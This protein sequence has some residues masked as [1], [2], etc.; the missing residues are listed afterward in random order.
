MLLDQLQ[1]LFLSLSSTRSIKLLITSRPH[2]PVESVFQDV[3]IIPLAAH[4]LQNDI[5]AF[6]QTEVDKLEFADTLGDEVQKF[7]I[8]RA[9]GMFLWVS[10]IVDDLKKSTNTTPRAI[11][12]KLESLP[13][14]L[15]GVYM[16]ILE[17]IPTKDQAAA[18]TILQ[19][20]VWAIRPL[21]L[22]ELRIAIAILPHRSLSSMQDDMEADLRQVLRLIFGP[23]LRIEADTTVHLVHQSAK[24]FLR[25]MNLAMIRDSA[26]HPPPPHLC[27]L[28]AE[29][30]RQC[31]QPSRPT[32]GDG[33]AV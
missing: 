1:D 28:A 20:V 9:K 24:D 17:K 4:N 12:K 3:S 32:A 14:D 11:K 6:V 5:V 23:M 26:N 29:S 2:I 10:L 18:E 13:P 7:L 31:G 33:R 27:L 15:P 21:T 25:N 22:E 30:N 16:N 19:W 8:H